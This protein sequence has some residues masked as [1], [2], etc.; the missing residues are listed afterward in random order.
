M[1]SFQAI[2]TRPRISQQLTGLTR[3][4]FETLLADLERARDGDR[5]QR[6][7]QRPA[8][9]RRRPGGGAKGALPTPA[10]RLAFVFSP[11]ASTP[12]RGPWRSSS[13]PAGAGPAS[14]PIA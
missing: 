5:R 4:A 1:L 13:A 14:G 3:A 10:A 8:P 11:S 2:R 12:P 9:G 6:D 7:R